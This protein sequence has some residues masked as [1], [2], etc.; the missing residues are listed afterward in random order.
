MD[1]MVWPVTPG[2]SHVLWRVLLAGTPLTG[3]QTVDIQKTNHRK[4]STVHATFALHADPAALATWSDQGPP[5]LLEVQAAFPVAGQAPSWQSVFVGEASD[6][7]IDPATGTVDVAGRD[8]A[9]RLIDGKTRSPYRNNTGSEIASMVAAQFGMTADVDATTTMAGSYYQLEHDKLVQDSLG[10][11]TT[12]WDLLCF[13]AQY[14]DRDLWV[15]GR[16]LYYKMPVDIQ[17]APAIPFTWQPA[18][19]VNG[20]PR[21]SVTNIKMKRSLTLAKGVQVVVKIWNSKSKSNSKVSFPTSAS[22]DAQIYSYVKP[23]MSPANALIFAQ[24]KYADIIRHERALPTSI[25]GSLVLTPRS[26][27]AVSGLPGSS[28]NVRYAV[29]ELTHSFAG[30]GF[31][32]SFTLKNHSVQSGSSV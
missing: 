3:C 23:G 15:D 21:A 17:S 4:A 29:D 12:Y 24:S 32:T 30:T 31:R 8:L 5:V 14:D 28:F 20:F 26:V 19:S 16:T 27:L 25:P 6:I 11:S 7:T 22:A 18:T 9:G 13:L 10:K 2:T 1:G